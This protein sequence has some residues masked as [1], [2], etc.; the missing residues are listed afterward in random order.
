MFPSR[1]F[2]VG[3]HRASQRRR[4]S[5]SA[6]V[7]W[8]CSSCLNATTRATLLRR[9][10]ISS[11]WAPDRS[12]EKFLCLRRY[13]L[14]TRPTSF[15]M[16]FSVYAHPQSIKSGCNSTVGINSI[17]SAPRTVFAGAPK[18]GK[19]KGRNLH[20]IAGH[21]RRRLPSPS[22]SFPRV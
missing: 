20:G 2:D 16:W 6:G 17:S 19:C 18:N 4:C 8:A 14:R 1:P 7:R 11:H 21:A 10:L 3:L 22:R 12:S 5:S 15:D 13:F 9:R